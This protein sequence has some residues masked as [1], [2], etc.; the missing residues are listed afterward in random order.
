MNG[1]N[2]LDPNEIMT[3]PKDECILIING[4][5]PFY[6]K[7]Y[8]LTKHPNF[9]ESGDSPKGKRFDCKKEIVNYGLR[10]KSSG[11]EPGAEPG[12]EFYLG[13]E[14]KMDELLKANQISS[15][16]EA[17]SRI[18]LKKGEVIVNETINQD[19]GELDFDYNVS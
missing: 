1:R 2:L 12:S 5:F 8:D 11:T 19:T 13:K 17:V 7:K 16:K 14:K 6:G 3:M 10:Q 4:M 9:D 15:V 18:V